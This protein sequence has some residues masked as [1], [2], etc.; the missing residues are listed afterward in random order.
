MAIYNSAMNFM[1]NSEIKHL[2]GGICSR[3]ARNST[4]ELYVSFV[5]ALPD[6]LCALGAIASN[7]LKLFA[8]VTLS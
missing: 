1:L 2:F 7:T 3:T 4:R 6:P 5:L 8:V